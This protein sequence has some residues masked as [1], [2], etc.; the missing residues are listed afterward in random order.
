MIKLLPRSLNAAARAIPDSRVLAGNSTRRTTE[1]LDVI[2]SS[3][4]LSFSVYADEPGKEIWDLCNSLAPSTRSSGGLSSQRPSF[5]LP[6]WR[7]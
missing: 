2:V 6:R 3:S 1:G 7:T 5:T 4:L